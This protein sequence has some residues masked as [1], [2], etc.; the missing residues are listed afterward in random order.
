MIKWKPIGQTKNCDKQLTEIK[1]IVLIGTQVLVALF[2]LSLLNSCTKTEIVY[3][4]VPR[5]P[6]TCIDSLDTPTDMLECLNEYSI[7]Y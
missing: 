4:E 6:V 5:E 2:L 7:K 3:V 1:Q